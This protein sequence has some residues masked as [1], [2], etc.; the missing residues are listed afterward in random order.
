MPSRHG[1]NKQTAI[2]A[3]ESMMAQAFAEAH[4]MLKPGGTLGV[5]YAHKTTLGWSTLVD[6]FRLA[7]FVVTEAWPLDT[8]MK[9][10]LRGDGFG[11]ARLQHLPR[12]PQ[13]G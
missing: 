12:R 7:G 11:R 1:G 2:S 13:A 4:R 10:R 5:V 9:A 8:E 3:Y 6:A